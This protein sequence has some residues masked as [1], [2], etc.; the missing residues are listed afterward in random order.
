MAFTDKATNVV[1]VIDR[2][3][4]QHLIYYMSHSLMEAPKRYPPL[5]KATFIIKMV[6]KKHIHYF[7]THEVVVL[8]LYPMKN[9]LGKP[10]Q[11]GSLSQ[12]T[13]ELSEFKIHYKPLS[14]IKGQALV[15]TAPL[16]KFMEEVRRIRDFAV[17][18]TR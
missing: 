17:S 6:A 9:I 5:D 10:D 3:G 7:R 16:S 4:K 2:E 1:L 13:I 8:I 15:E 12:I 18:S 11:S 14:A